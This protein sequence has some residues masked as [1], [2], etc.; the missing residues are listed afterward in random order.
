[1]SCAKHKTQYTAI[2]GLQRSNI[3]T[4]NPLNK[5]LPNLS[6]DSCIVTTAPVVKW[7]FSASPPHSK[8]VNRACRRGCQKR[9]NEKTAARILRL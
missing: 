9:N 3:R 5:L 4:P 8:V 2:D 6:R 7:A 1:M